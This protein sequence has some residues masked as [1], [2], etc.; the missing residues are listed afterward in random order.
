MKKHMSFFSFM[1]RGNGE[2]MWIGTQFIEFMEGG[3]NE[4]VAT[5]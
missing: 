1:A 3:A 2:L 5:F 4:L